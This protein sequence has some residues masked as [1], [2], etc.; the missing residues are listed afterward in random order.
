M[1][2]VEDAREAEQANNLKDG[3][4][5]GMATMSADLDRCKTIT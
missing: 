4:G 3:K 1:S 5:K 2:T